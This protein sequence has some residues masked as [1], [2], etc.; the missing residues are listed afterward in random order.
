MIG[1]FGLQRG[2]CLRHALRPTSIARVASL[3]EHSMGGRPWDDI[4]VEAQWAVADVGSP[5]T[6]LRNVHAGRSA[7]FGDESTMVG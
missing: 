7:G 4:R 3:V 5:G 2:E 6:T 1:A